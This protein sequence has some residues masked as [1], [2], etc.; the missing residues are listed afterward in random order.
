MDFVSAHHGAIPAAAMTAE[1][2][3]RHPL[4]LRAKLEISAACH[5]FAK[6]PS[7]CVVTELN[8]MSVVADAARKASRELGYTRMWSIHPSQIRTIVAAFRPEADEIDE[9]VAILAAA[10][11]ADWAPIGHAGTLHDRA[12]YRYYWRLLLRARN[13]GAALPDA[14]I[15]RFFAGAAA[16]SA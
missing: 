6:T 12:S 16:P 14:A 9:A 3:F 15:R 4:V 2:Q 8:D 5:A 7:H 1:G 10:Q 11:A 13:A